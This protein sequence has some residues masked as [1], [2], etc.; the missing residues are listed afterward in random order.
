MGRI[1][2][3]I[4]KKLAR[5]P[6]KSPG[7]KV[8]DKV[9]KLCLESKMVRINNIEKCFDRYWYGEAKR[10]AWQNPWAANYIIGTI[11]NAKKRGLVGIEGLVNEKIGF[12]TPE[13]AILE[14]RAQGMGK[15]FFHVRY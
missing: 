1:R 6:K 2:A 5:K 14:I 11:K 3:W 15:F 10:L 13:N 7:K 12:I 4:R 9:I 8:R